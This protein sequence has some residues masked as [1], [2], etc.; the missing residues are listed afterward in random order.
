VLTATPMSGTFTQAFSLDPTVFTSGTIHTIGV[1]LWDSNN[2]ITE[3]YVS[4]RAQY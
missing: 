2:N 1:K 4:F 3:T